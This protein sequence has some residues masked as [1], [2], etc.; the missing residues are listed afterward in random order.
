MIG[1]FL[2]AFGFGIVAT[3]LVRA[4]SRKLKILDTPDQNKKRHGRVVPLWGGLAIF[5]VFWAL[6]G[7]DWFGWHDASLALIGSPLF[8]LFVAS[9]IF[10]LIGLADDVR[11]LSF[12]ARLPFLIAGIL[13]VAAASPIQ[14]LTNPG[15]GFWNI[16][17]FLGMGLVALWLM[18][19]TVSLKILDGVDGLAASIGLVGALV[20]FG[21]TLSAKFY[22]PN[23]ALVALLFA[24]ALAGFLIF[25]LPPASIFLGESGSLFV[26]LMLGG[27]SIMAG[28]KIAT[29]LLVMAVPVL[30]M[31]R[32]I[33]VRIRRGQKIF[34]GDRTHLPLRLLDRGWSAWQVL[35]VL[36]GAALAAGL[37]GLLVQSAA[38]ILALLIVAFSFFVL[39]LRLGWMK[40]SK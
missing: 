20:I 15:G 31:L 37:L 14:K 18:V 19:T 5:A 4:L 32:V 7:V 27:L 35:L 17:T 21:L 9:A 3:L 33:I 29:A 26:G 12:G 6:V 10:L 30:D 22:Q 8:A 13:F 23:V 40:D 39:M 1:L 2:L 28:S 36:V 24:G 25:N 38:K 16:G 34:E 11:P